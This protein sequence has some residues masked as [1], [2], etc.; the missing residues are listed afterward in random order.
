[1]IRVLQNMNYG[2]KCVNLF[3][4][5]ML[6]ES[7]LLI[8]LSQLRIQVDVSSVRYDVLQTH[9]KAFKKTTI[10]KTHFYVV[11]II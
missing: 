5:V 2:V 7:L 8:H 9:G 3:L 4:Q 11:F 6:R 10:A 1:M